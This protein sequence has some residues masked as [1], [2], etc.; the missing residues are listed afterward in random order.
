MDFNEMEFDEN[1]RLIVKEAK[2][3]KEEQCIVFAE[4]NNETGICETYN[5]WKIK[6]YNHGAFF[7]VPGNEGFVNA[8]IEMRNDLELVVWESKI[9][10]I[11]E[12]TFKDTEGNDYKYMSEKSVNIE[13]LAYN[14]GGYTVEILGHDVLSTVYIEDGRG[15]SEVV[16]EEEE[17]TEDNIVEED[18][19]EEYVVE[20]KTEEI[21]QVSEEEI[22]KFNEENKVEDLEDL[23]KQVVDTSIEEI[24]EV[25]EETIE[26]K[27]VVVEEVALSVEE[28]SVINEE[29]AIEIEEVISEDIKLEE[30]TV[31]ET[32][33]DT[34]EVFDNIV[35]DNIEIKEEGIK[36]VDKKE[37]DKV[38][39]I[40]DKFFELVP[41][42]IKIEKFSDY[43]S[44][45]FDYNI[46]IEKVKNNYIVTVKGLA[47]KN[48]KLLENEEIY[49]NFDGGLESFIHKVNKMLKNMYMMDEKSLSD[50][51]IMAIVDKE[52][53]INIE[54]FDNVSTM[55]RGK[56]ISY[57]N[58]V[59]IN[60]MYLT[61]GNVEV[62]YVDEKGK[63]VIAS[64]LANDEE[65]KN[66][67]LDLASELDGYMELIDESGE[68]SKFRCLADQL[69]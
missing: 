8:R 17:I 29:S 54:V 55:E 60:T 5:V 38:K 14:Y 69:V 23:L 31:E 28:Q 50:L 58:N 9:V 30:E 68:I 41:A 65:S 46:I 48:F 22:E 35:N 12:N 1:G 7:I 10:Q 4:L 59:S 21:V 2:V 18:I 53:D 45:N 16:E 42:N 33:E 51:T 64:A 57:L 20:E 36:M 37:M 34:Q 19:Q 49:F 39:Q 25:N 3:E 13:S 24:N 43:Y 67:M 26:E 62:W 6:D 44:V 27:E 47:F 40:A 52:D 63:R 32:M 56:A 61:N 66:M 11:P 15:Q